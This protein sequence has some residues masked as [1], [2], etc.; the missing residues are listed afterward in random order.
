ME[1]T[2]DIDERREIRKQIRELRNK[3]FDE[4]MK[5]ISSGEITTSS[6]TNGISARKTTVKTETVEESGDPYGLL[7]YKS[8]D[9]L[10][11]LVSNF[12]PLMLNRPY[13]LILKRLVSGRFIQKKNIFLESFHRYDMLKMLKNVSSM[14]VWKDV[15][16]HVFSYRSSHN[17]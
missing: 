13:S 16:K 7:E 6:I 1:Q 3:K 14:L 15:W 4:E 12:T 2:E 17:C 9:A 10:Q 11:E 5:K 8:E